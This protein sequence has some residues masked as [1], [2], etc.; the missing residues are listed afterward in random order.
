MPEHKNI[1]VSA[2]SLNQFLSCERS[3]KHARVDEL[4][5][6]RRNTPE[7][8]ETKGGAIE[9]GD[10]F[11]VLL[12]IYYK[13]LILELKKKEAATLAK[14]F[15]RE[16]AP[17]S[18][19]PISVTEYE[20]GIFDDYVK[21]YINDYWKPKTVEEAFSFILHEDEE[22]TILFE[23][24]IDLEVE[25][26]DIGDMTVDHKTASSFGPTKMMGNQFKTYLLARNR[27]R[28][29]MNKIFLQKSMGEKGR[30]SRSIINFQPQVIA[31]WA[32]DV[33]FHIK[34]MAQY[35][36]HNW[37]PRRETSCYNFN[38]PCAYIPLCSATPRTLEMIARRDYEK[39]HDPKWD[40]QTYELRQREELK[41]I[42]QH[43]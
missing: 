19:L 10:F 15:S 41:W 32:E 18:G 5:Q 12:R 16:Y 40:P 22:L 27:K 23:G 3:F 36:E 8:T 13:C 30:F 39:V 31:D 37:F 26:K 24:V 29:T 7:I 9:K 6:I 35:L 20:I 25:V 28:L 11:H 14:M 33:I 34:Q 1:R 17:K 38:K 43:A 42:K 21:Y 4:V 2:S